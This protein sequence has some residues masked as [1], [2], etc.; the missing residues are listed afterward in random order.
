MT[1]GGSL[2][3]T[4]SALR[5][6][7]PAAG[8]G[9][10][11]NRLVGYA[12]EGLRRC[13]MPDLGRYSY[14]FRFDLPEPRNESVPEREAFYTLFVLLGLSQ[15]DA[16]G[17]DY[18]DVRETYRHCCGFLRF[19][20]ARIYMLGT[21]LWAGARLDLEPPGY[22]V[23][24]IRRITAAPRNLGRA[25]AQDVGMLLSGVT[26][27]ALA[28]GTEWRRMAELLA[29]HLCAHYFH[30]V[31]HIFY[32]EGIGYR[33]RFSSFASQVYAI[34]ALYQFGE[35]FDPRAVGIAE[36]AA[37][38]MIALQGPRGEWG[39]FFYVPRACV[40]D[41][42]EIYSVHQHGMAPAFL[43][44]AV[45]HNAPGARAALVTGFRW[46]F[47]D[48]AMEV[49]MLRPEERM[50]YRSQARAGE[51]AGRWR[52]AGRSLVGAA[53]GRGDRVENHQSLVLCRECR[54]Y[55]LGWILWSFGGRRDF[56][57]LTECPEFL[58]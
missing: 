22:L 32:N 1:V 58:V 25:T 10:A 14:R 33:R 37:A 7:V 24:R 45:S 56:P 38:R 48:N 30:P 36:R 29:A 23:D 54:S 8:R 6:G 2:S 40:V 47:G 49:S 46:L 20:T 34:L 15:L 9:T 18:V 26:A 3:T 55:E 42:Y 39:W 5:I 53:L 21:A 52:R 11:D 28:G 50:F 41:F 27:M 44:H 12:L 17:C 57:E 13:W 19:P 35:S 43:R 4:A 51:L 16:A 31:S